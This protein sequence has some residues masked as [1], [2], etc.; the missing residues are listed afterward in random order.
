LRAGGEK[1][2]EREKRERKKER[3]SEGGGNST[4]FI[5]H[6]IE[7][8][9][10]KVYND[11]YAPH[12]LSRWVVVVLPQTSNKREQSRVERKTVIIRPFKC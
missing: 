1:Q 5:L 2:K 11:L 6:S 3:A 4:C 7:I 10:L 12:S 8:V 9:V